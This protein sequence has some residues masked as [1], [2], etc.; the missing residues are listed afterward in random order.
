MTEVP[1]LTLHE[2]ADGVFVWL[3]PGGE[4]GVSNAGAVVDD[5]GVTVIDTLMVRVAM[6]AVR[7]GGQRARPAGPPDRC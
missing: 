2:L 5:D 7:G 6:G 4:S 3:Q 1:V